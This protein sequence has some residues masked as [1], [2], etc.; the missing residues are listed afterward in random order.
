MNKPTM[1]IILDGFGISKHKKGNAVLAAKMPT[2]KNLLTHYP[3]TTLKASGTAVGLL[4]GYIGNSEVGHTTLGTGRIVET[5]L[6][7]FDEAIE[8]KSIF[9]NKTLLNNLK[10]I[11]PNNALHL[12]GL[13]SDGGVHSHEKHLYTLIKLAKKLKIK[14]VFIHPILDGRDVPPKSAAKYLKRLDKVCRDLKCGKIATIHGRFYAMDRDNN[15]DRTKISYDIL[16]DPHPSIHPSSLEAST[17]TQGERV[18]R[19]E[20]IT[21]RQVPRFMYTARPEYFAKQNVSKGAVFQEALKN[22]YT[23][24]I[25]DEF[26][27]PIRLIEDGKIKKSDGVIFFNFR[28]DRARQLTESFINPSF[29]HFK[30]QS[31]NLKFFTTTTRY[32][33]EF[34]KFKN[35]ILFEKPIIKNTLLDEIAKKQK[36]NSVFIIAET[37]KYAHVTYFFKGLNEKQFKNETQVLIPSIKIKSYADK[38]EMSAAKITTQVIKSLKTAP[39]FFYLINYANP[40]MVGHSGDFEA[41]VKACEFVDKQLKKL[42]DLLVEKMDGTMF[43]LADHGNAE[44]MIDLKTGNP[45]TSHTKN[46]VPFVVVNKKYKNKKLKFN[47]NLGLCNVAPTILKF[48]GLKIPAK[49]EQ[50]T[51]L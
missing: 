40:D 8:N 6:K 21:D 36:N 17:D 27:Y 31:L 34:K 23:Q 32:K 35:D 9:K 18:P 11:K 30:T 45:K 49:M 28:P 50:K 12:I 25:T 19:N 14:N 22:S 29:K 38:P 46:L 39:A 44:E 41:T 20:T 3:H 13:L 51:I 4:P 33:D 42:Y 26:F 10:K 37:E 16:C 43:I 24:D 7:K 1:L 15:W 5:T 48:L 2:W 47:K